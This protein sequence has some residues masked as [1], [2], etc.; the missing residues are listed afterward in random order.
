LP[1][2]PIVAM[3]AVERLEA[4][5][6]VVALAVPVVS[7]PESFVAAVAVVAVAFHGELSA[8]GNL[9]LVWCLPWG[10]WSADGGLIHR[11]NAALL[12][13][14]APRACTP[15]RFGPCAPASGG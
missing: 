4:A 3:V 12:R 14:T 9:A 2:V 7:L 1:V 8:L 15:V 13:F 10:V 5:V 6:L 11:G